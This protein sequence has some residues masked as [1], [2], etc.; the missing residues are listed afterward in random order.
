MFIYIYISIN[1][2]MYMRHDSIYPLLY[3][4]SIPAQA[5]AAPAAPSSSSTSASEPAGMDAVFAQINQGMS[6][7]A[8][9]KKVDKSQVRACQR[10]LHPV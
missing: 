8:G 6:I 5:P 3:T 10:N 4:M 9:L 7:T 2:Y 1:T